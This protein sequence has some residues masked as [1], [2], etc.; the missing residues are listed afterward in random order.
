VSSAA[1]VRSSSADTDASAR[2]AK[3]S[4]YARQRM[5]ART[6]WIAVPIVALMIAIWVLGWIFGY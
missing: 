2:A 6:G 1:S 3:H 5:G 4:S